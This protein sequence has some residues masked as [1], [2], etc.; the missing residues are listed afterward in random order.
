MIKQRFFYCPKCGSELNYQ[1]HITGDIPR[2]TC[3]DCSY[4][5]FENPAVGVAAIVFNEKNE[6]LLGKR[7]YGKR[8][9]LWCIPCGYLEYHEDVYDGTKREFKE[10]T[11]LD[12]NI[13]RV[14]DVHSNFHDPE[15]HS[16]GIWFL[17][18][19]IGGYPEARDDLTD[20]GF[21]NLNNLP[22]LAFST[23]KKVIKK[24]KED[25]PTNNV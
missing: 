7:K 8:K 25:C 21:F 3:T 16:V 5:L 9:G 18:D 14:Y 23:D 2:L 15:K 13:D 24:L 19:I 10:E 11:N 4:I 6:I 1:I 20:I 22:E 17:G 12:I